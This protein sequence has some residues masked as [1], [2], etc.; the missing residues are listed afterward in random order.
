MRLVAFGSEGP[1][2][3]IGGAAVIAA[4][5]AGGI[6]QHNDNPPGITGNAHALGL[7]AGAELR[8]MEFMQ[9]YP[10]TIN[11]PG[12][13]RLL[14]EPDEAN[15]GRVLNDKG[16]DILDK[17]DITERPAARHA[18]DRTSQALFQEMELEGNEV[19]ID[20]THLDREAWL[21]H[22]LSPVRFDLFDR[23]Y[24]AFG[25]PIR[26]SPVAHFSVGGLCINAHG[27]TTV[28]GL[29]AAGEAAGGV[30]G[31]NRMGGNSLAETVVFGHRAGL[32]AAA[33]AE[34]R[35]QG[36]EMTKGAPPAQP[37]DG[38]ID[39]ARLFEDLRQ[40]MW[41]HAGIRRDAAGLAAGLA[42]VLGIK[43]QAGQ[44]GDQLVEL[45]LA[46]QTAELI[47]EAAI[48]REESRGAHYRVDFPAT[49]D[50]NWRGNLCVQRQGDSLEWRY[51]A[52]EASPG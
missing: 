48:R 5:G 2:E 44:G 36:R 28:G 16:E 37:G 12:K 25:Q 47:I 34:G 6:Y 38:A 4:G 51:D 31:A 1:M 32:A 7:A 21:G 23:R 35:G 14:F 18:R 45:R 52:I 11:E 39:G 27:A 22:N 8:D 50:A 20:L 10:M 30:H 13:A 46:S 42:R 15:Q 17:Y 26:L 29:Y 9:F 49:D 40:V 33:W 41:L 43:A 19:F 24:D 3:L